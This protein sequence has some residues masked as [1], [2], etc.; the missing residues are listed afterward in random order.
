M[1]RLERRR[2]IYTVAGHCHDLAVRLERGDDAQFLFGHDPREYGDGFQPF[3]EL[4]IVQ[5]FKIA[6]RQHVARGYSSLAGDGARS[7]SMIPGD[8]DDPNAG[9]LAVRDCGRDRQPQG[10]G[11]SDQ[12]NQRK[13]KPFRC[14]RPI[15]F[16]GLG[17]RHAEHANAAR[18]HRIDC[19]HHGGP[20]C[21]S[22]AAQFGN[23]LRCA[24][25]C[26]G[27]QCVGR[28]TLPNIRHSQQFWSQ[29]VTIDQ[30]CGIVRRSLQ[31]RVDCNFHRIG[32]INRTRADAGCGQG[33]ERFGQLGRPRQH[34]RFT[35]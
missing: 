12:S 8:H 26:N 13:R 22:Q 23:R 3:C 10:V 6:A 34:C 19:R 16:R 5:R 30:F 9:R 31:S 17:T 27:N 1:R 33:G 2:I 11:K 28:G 21:E 15:L 29:P 20:F 32:G 24:L 35:R 25:G 14:F 18:R 4:C 7:R